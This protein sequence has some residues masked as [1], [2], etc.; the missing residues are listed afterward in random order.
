MSSLRSTNILLLMIL[1]V[2]AVNTFKDKAEPVKAAAI[3]A[4]KVVSMPASTNVNVNGI[5]GYT[6]QSNAAL[7][8]KGTIPVCVMNPSVAVDADL[9]TEMDVNVTDWSAGALDVDADFPAEM[10]I[11]ADEPLDVNI[12][13]IQVGGILDSKDVLP[14]EVKNSSIHPLPVESSILDPVWVRV[15][16]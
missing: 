13:K 4:V 6:W 10:K 8:Q 2:L 5:Y 11:A 1:L 7:Y 3:Q 9:P 16:D 12:R 14:V 15:A